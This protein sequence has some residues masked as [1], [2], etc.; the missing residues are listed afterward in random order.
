MRR[1]S[2]VGGKGRAQWKGGGSWDMDL[3]M[4][5]IDWMRFIKIKA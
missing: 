1:R 3:S 5:A 2:N 4:E